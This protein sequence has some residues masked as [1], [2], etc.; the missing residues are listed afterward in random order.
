MPQYKIPETFDIFQ[1]RIMEDGGITLGIDHIP[2][3]LLGKYPIL[4]KL[5]P[6]DVGRITRIAHDGE[7]IYAVETLHTNPLIQELYDRGELP[8]YSIVADFEASPCE[9]GEADFVVERFKSIK[10]TDYVDEGGCTDCRVGVVPDGLVLSAKLSFTEEDN[11]TDEVVSL[12]EDEVVEEVMEATESSEEIEE[13]I[14]TTEDEV[15]EAEE[16]T[17]TTESEEETEK[18]EEDEE[19]ED[20]D[21]ETIETRLDRLEDAVGLLA[22]KAE[23]V[24]EIQ[25][26]AK[27][28][29]VTTL[30]ETHIQAGKVLPKEKDSLIQYGLDHEKSLTSM[31]ATRPVLIE[32][33]TQRSV[34]VEAE[35]GERDYTWKDYEKDKQRE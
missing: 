14:V 25:L 21:V 22:Q 26:Q 30:I 33:D 3:E 29:R 15:E 34:H 20:E 13:E 1:D 9:S 32:L 18:E 19:V 31:L 17:D 2:E 28:S 4:E 5:N 11:V 24:D 6:L 16:T 23:A 8:A 12:E 10:R 35:K 7:S 27:K